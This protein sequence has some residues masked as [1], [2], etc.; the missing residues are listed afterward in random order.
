MIKKFL[1]FFPLFLPHAFFLYPTKEKED[2][3]ES[4]QRT[5]RNRIV[6][7]M[8][9]RL[10]NQA[11]LTGSL[12]VSAPSLL[13]PN[14][15]RTIIFLTHHEVE[16]GALGV[17][18]NRPS[19]RT[20]GELTESPDGLKDV[21]VFEGGPVELQH[22]LLAR[23]LLMGNGA[24]FESFVEEEKNVLIS[25]AS[26]SNSMSDIQG[27]RAFAGYAGWSAGQLENE[28][29]EKSW[30]ILP[31]TAPLLK[32]VNTLEEGAASWRS[33][34]RELGPLYRLLAEA[35]DDLSLN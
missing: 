21:P 35:P 19:G 27:F 32:A 20:L 3:I 10:T 30:L 22:L 14:F 5:V 29:K 11:D 17:I 28:I 33:I 2:R 18:L 15:R 8:D 7:S 34:M 12:L 4:L 9:L 26:K 25:D 6:H 31:P 16:E 13:D 24:R 1:E 23:I